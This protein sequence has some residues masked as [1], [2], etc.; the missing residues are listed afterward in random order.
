M[1]VS[2]II[3]CLN[4]AATLD[5][6]LAALRAQTTDATFEVVVSDNGSTDGSADLARKWADGTFIVRVVDASSVKGINHSRNV[7][8]AGSESELLLFCD[9]DDRVHPGWIQGFWLAYKA[10]ARLVGGS[11]SRVF[12][13][14]SPALALETGLNNDLLFLPWATG[15]N[16][17]VAREVVA[18]CGPFDESFR[19]G[20][21][22]TEFF[23]RAQLAGFPLTYVSDAE[24]DYVQRAETKSLFRQQHLYGRSHAKLYS[25]FRD[26]GMPRPRRMSSVRGVAS[27]TARIVLGTVAAGRGHELRQHGLRQ[28]GQMTGRIAGSWA[29]RV[30]Y[31]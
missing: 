14:G 12:A 24:V 13:D 2:V 25:L 18:E 15:A 8:I 7:G 28:L 6:Q 31:V 17:G 4:G 1:D 30:W 21:D 20:G 11:V 19:G 10:G 22:E 27:G 16:C 5:R 26:A 23:W 9:V 3:P 29:H